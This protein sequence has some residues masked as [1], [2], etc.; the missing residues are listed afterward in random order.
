M[1]KIKTYYKNYL[2]YYEISNFLKN[3][4]DEKTIIVCIGT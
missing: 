2:A 1:N 3:H 4:I